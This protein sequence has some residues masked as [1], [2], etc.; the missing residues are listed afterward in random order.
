MISSLNVSNQIRDKTE[1]SIYNINPIGGSGG[2][3]KTPAD[4][5][6]SGF[7]LPGPTRMHGLLWTTVSPH[8]HRTVMVRAVCLAGKE[9][10]RRMTRRGFLLR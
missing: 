3:P 9:K 2:L 4:C 10:P 8:I 6:W 1:L 5:V 7:S